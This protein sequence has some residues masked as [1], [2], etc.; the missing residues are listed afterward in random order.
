MP[1]LPA[2]NHDDAEPASLGDLRTLVNEIDKNAQLGDRDIIAEARTALL[3][4]LH[5]SAKR[6]RQK[7]T[8]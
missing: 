5:A 4:L 2:Y 7:Y 8:D 6:L 3:G 1:D